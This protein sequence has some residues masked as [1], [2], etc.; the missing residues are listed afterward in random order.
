MAHDS[1]IRR[2]VGKGEN[3]KKWHSS[4]EVI[5]RMTTYTKGLYPSSLALS[6]NQIHLNIGSYLEAKSWERRSENRDHLYFVIILTSNVVKFLVCIGHCGGYLPTQYF[7]EST[8]QLCQV[9]V[10]KVCFIPRRSNCVSESDLSEVTPLL[11]DK[12][13]I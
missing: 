2:G 7:I 1:F 4:K 5:C 12:G 6:P 11:S 8:L 13:V 3:G 10:C 9:S